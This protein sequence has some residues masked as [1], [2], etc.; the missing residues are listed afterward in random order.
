MRKNVMTEVTMTTENENDL[1]KPKTQ[2]WTTQEQEH[3]R[4]RYGCE[5]LKQNCTLEEAKDKNFPSDAY[6]V[7]YIHND[8]VC[9]DLTRGKKVFIFDMYYDKLG[10]EAIQKIDWGYGRINPKVWGYKAP[11]KKKRK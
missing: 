11:E 7:T 1:S 8:K 6:I 10:K 9:Y 4:S 2:I 5:I 3:V